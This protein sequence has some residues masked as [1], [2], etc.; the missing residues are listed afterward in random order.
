MGSRQTSRKPWLKRHWVN[1]LAR[2]QEEFERPVYWG[3][4]LFFVHFSQ[5]GIS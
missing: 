3:T 2:E 5:V 1:A 4:G